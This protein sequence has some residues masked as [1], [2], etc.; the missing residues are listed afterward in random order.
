MNKTLLAPNSLVFRAYILSWFPQDSVP[1][2]SRTELLS[3]A[4]TSQWS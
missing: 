1:S 4:L 3:I 2:A